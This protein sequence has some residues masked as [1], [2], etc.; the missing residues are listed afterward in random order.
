MNCE[1]PQKHGFALQT[2]QYFKINLLLYLD[3]ISML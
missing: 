3:R 2:L 1:D